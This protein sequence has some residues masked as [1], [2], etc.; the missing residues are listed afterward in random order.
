MPV[1]LVLL[2]LCFLPPAF[3]IDIALPLDT[4]IETKLLEQKQALLEE[5]KHELVAIDKAL[6]IAEQTYAQQKQNLP[7]LE[8]TNS[9][10][11]KVELERERFQIELENLQLKSEA[12]KKQLGE[13]R[14]YLTT[15]KAQMGLSLSEPEKQQLEQ[16]VQLQT[17]QVEVEQLLSEFLTARI[18]IMQKLRDTLI[19]WVN[20]LRKAHLIRQQL[21]QTA[22]AKLKQQYYLQKV[23]ELKHKL[24]SASPSQRVILEFE[25]F[26]N[27]ELAS[28]VLNTLEQ[29]Q[30]SQ[31]LQR[32]QQEVTTAKI[33]QMP[34]L[35]AEQLLIKQIR[36]LEDSQS[37]ITQL[38][39]LLANK[40]DLN[41]RTQSNLHKRSE[42]WTGKMLTSYKQADDILKQAHKRLEQAQDA[43]TILKL[44][45]N[46]F[47]QV[48]TAN[49]KQILHQK[50]VQRRQF[51]Q[52][53]E[54]L[55]QLVANITEFPSLFKNSLITLKN[56]VYAALLMLPLSSILLL[57]FCIQ[58]W[59][60]GLLWLKSILNRASDYLTKLLVVTFIANFGLVLVNLVKR[61][62]VSLAIIGSL[63]IS[64]YFLPLSEQT[65][66][67]LTILMV[68]WLG[69]QLSTD[70]AFL[71]FSPYFGT[72][73]HY[74]N[75]YLQISWIS[76]ILATAALI[77]A[78][79]HQWELNALTLE[80]IDTGFM[81]LLSIAIIPA[82]SMRYFLMY[83]LEQEN[84]QGY[85]FLSIRI[86]TLFVPLSLLSISLLGMI[87]Y[88]NLGWIVAHQAY[89]LIFVL[90]LWLVVQ[91][92]LRD[93]IHVLKNFVMQRSQYGLLWTQDIIPLI[94]NVL[95]ISLFI[96]S[97]MLLSWL[98]SWHNDLAFTGVRRFLFDDRLIQ[99]GS[100]HISLFSILLS[101]L[102]LRA[103]FWLGSWSR[104]ITY[105][106]IYASVR[107]LGIRNSLSVFTQ[108]FVVLFGLL[109]IL[110][111]LG[112]D[113]TTMTI[114]AGAL[115]VGIGFG[116]QNIANNF[117]SGI[118]LLIERPLK[119]GDYVNIAGVHEGEVTRI[120]IRSLT[121]QAWNYQEVVVPNSEVI[122]NAFT[123]WT[124]T[125]DIMRTTLYFRI[126]Y[127]TDP[128]FVRNLL[129][130]TLSEVPELLKEPENTMVNVW[131]FSEYA[132]IFRVDYY[133]DV[134][135]DGVLKMRTKINLL[136]WDTL[137]KT[138]VK[139]PYPQH[140]VW[141]QHE[142]E[143]TTPH[144]D[145]YVA[146]QRLDENKNLL[147]G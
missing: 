142:T 24:G 60:L 125:N 97:L 29:E 74:Q 50:L 88:I 85:W 90:L 116:L 43:V 39:D 123:N 67:F 68:I 28:E 106:W 80:V 122:S 63:I 25:I 7:E 73:P 81:L 128:H 26:D 132:I 79:A 146:D 111:I 61:N 100:V 14:Q 103:I 18:I 13:S 105:R 138:G 133:I 87:G 70:L 113:L 104:R 110:Q 129:L 62:F 41:V 93:F 141:V 4:Q 54:T 135:K 102:G 5:E 12:R 98:N 37:R 55:H 36:L 82:M 8:I 1:Y 140:S 121:V 64:L 143:S 126:G 19:E 46:T 30:I 92:L 49:Y 89:W 75:V 9:N 35:Q 118:L 101:L 65:Q 107:D 131:E 108:Y 117:V 10:I 47:N 120:G 124:L 94:H 114:F 69:A 20:M 59:V 3:A 56:E 53:A 2:L 139:I 77:T 21:D 137:Q 32:W 84:I 40:L 78:L 71:L 119:T 51:L 17:Q 15:F 76:K 127:D 38:L 99:I 34:I 57:L 136:I 91:G 42:T 95:N 115:G 130:E 52:D 11:A 58:I 31:Q 22:K 147:G 144:L 134:K 112:I 6:T 48:L 109:I 145:E 66:Y 45:A 86:F 44:E 33:N 72:L 83:L 16:N 96:L 23:V 27:E